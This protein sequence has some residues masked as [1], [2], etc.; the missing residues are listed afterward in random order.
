MNDTIRF[1][2]G[3]NQWYETYFEVASFIEL[4]L[5]SYDDPDHSYVHYIQGL[6]GRAALKQLAREW[7]DKFEG[8]HIGDVWLDD[9]YDAIEDFLVKENSYQP[10]AASS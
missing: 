4:T 6:G 3:F 5:N 2:G 8:Q 9:Y 10:D 7:T 1:E